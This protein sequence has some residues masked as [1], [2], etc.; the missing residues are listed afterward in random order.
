MQKEDDQISEKD[1]ALCV[2]LG[3][4]GLLFA[5]PSRS[6]HSLPWRIGDYSRSGVLRPDQI[7]DLAVSF[8][9]VTE[10]LS[11]LSQCL[12]TSL[13]TNPSML[14]AIDELGSVKKGD[15]VAASTFAAV[16]HAR[17]LLAN[18]S[19][20][21]M[22]LSPRWDLPKADRAFVRQTKAYLEQLAQAM[23]EL[24]DQWRR[25]AG[26]EHLTVMYRLADERRLPDDRRD[27]VLHSIF[28]FWQSQGRKLT[29]TTDGITSERRGIIFAFVNAVLACVTDPC[30][31]L[32][33]ETIV[34][35]IRRWKAKYAG[36]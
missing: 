24:E 33:E 18:A 17:R 6:K 10:D 36:S 14:R 28:S 31:S 30:D 12:G 25:L 26:R 1:A 2:L 15:D 13:D 35:E 7:E 21:T 20:G 32:G 8:D 23:E 4:K 5:A 11:S 16:R 19:H 34:K 29:Y 3:L 27:W 22:A 9:L